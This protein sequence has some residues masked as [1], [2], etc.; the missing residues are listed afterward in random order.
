MAGLPKSFHGFGRN[1]ALL[2]ASGKLFVGF[3]SLSGSGL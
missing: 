2:E 3:Q 1:V